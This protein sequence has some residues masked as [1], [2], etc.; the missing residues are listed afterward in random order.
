[1]EKEKAVIIKEFVELAKTD[2]ASGN[3][4]AI[5][6]VLIQKLEALGCRVWEDEAGKEIGG[7][8]GNLHAYLEG[9]LPGCILFMAHMDRVQN[10]LGIRPELKDGILKSDGSTILAADDLSGVTAIMDGIRRL[11]AS[12]EKYCGVEIIFSICEEVG[13]KGTLY[14]DRSD[15][16]SKFGYVLDSPG[17]IGRILDSAMGK[18]QMFLHVSGKSAHA[19]YPELGISAMR[20]AVRILAELEDGRVDEETVINWS[21][22]E[23]LTPFNAVSDHA[24]AKGLAMSRDNGKLQAYLDKFVA[25]TERI[26]KETGAEAEAEYHIDYPSFLVK[27]DSLSIRVARKTMEN[28]QITP[29]VEHGAGGFDANRMNGYGIEMIGLATGYTGNHTKEEQLVAED[30]IRAGEMVEQIVLTYSASLQEERL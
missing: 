2:A 13:L 24:E 3:E 28:L 21:W 9:E 27:E 7:N 23:S 20:A 15:I 10:G 8:T 5:A 11:K 18:A 4:R 16:R 14:L 19:A 22:M 30:L 26:S 1:M 6:D 12:G 25:V 29:L 17:R